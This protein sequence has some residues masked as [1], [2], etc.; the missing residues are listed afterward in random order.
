MTV[1]ELLKILE[2]VDPDRQI[3]LANDTEDNG[4]SPPV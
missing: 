1:R 2:G 4:Y 3:I